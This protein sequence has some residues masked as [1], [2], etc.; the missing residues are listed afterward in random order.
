MQHM[1]YARQSRGFDITD[2][3]SAL[4]EESH[5]KPR[6]ICSRMDQAALAFQK[7]FVQCIRSRRSA[8]L[9]R[10]GGDTVKDIVLTDRV[11]SPSGLLSSGEIQWLSVRFRPGRD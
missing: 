9:S 6:A 4:E 11:P 5:Q 8:G 3:I 10:S 1:L 2:L 7:I